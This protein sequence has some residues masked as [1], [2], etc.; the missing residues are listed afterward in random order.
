MKKLDLHVH[1]L[2]SN[3]D[4]QFEFDINRLKEYVTKRKIDGIAITNHN[5]FDRG[6][7]EE[8]ARELSQICVVLPGI[9][10]NLGD[11]SV[12]HMLCIA[13]PTDM[14]EFT[15]KCSQVSNRIRTAQDFISYEDLKKIFGDLSRYLWIPHYDKKPSIDKK[16]LVEMQNDILCGEVTSVKK[17][18]YCSKDENLLT[19]VYFSDFRSSAD[20]D[21]RESYPVRQ[22]YFDISEITLRTIKMCLSDKS[23]VVLNA[24]DGNAI[25]E[26]IPGLPISTGLNVMLGGRSSGKTFTLNEIA[27]QHENIK[28]IKQF[29]LIEP[30]P[31]KAAKEFTDN[32]ANKR[33][34][35]EELYFKEFTEVVDDIKD[36]SIV[37]DDNMVGEYVQ[38]LVEHANEVDRADMF[39]KCRLYE[40][41]EFP[42]DNPEGLKKL[43]SSVQT[44]LEEHEYR[45]VIDDFVDRTALIHLFDE[46]TRIYSQRREMD[47]KKQWINGIVIDIKNSLQLKTSST[48][49]KD[50]DLYKVAINRVKIKK[51]NKLVEELKKTS[52]IVST[53]VGGF[54]V[55][56][57]KKPF[58]SPSELRKRSGKRDVRFSDMMNTYN[59]N[60]YSFLISLKEVEAIPENEYYKYFADVEYD[61]LNQYNASI[62]GGERAEFT[63]L[64]QIKDA[65]QYDM[66]LIDEPESSFDNIFLKQRVNEIIKDIADKIPVII[67]THNNTVGESIKP[68]YLIHTY[69]MIEAQQP[70]Y[71]LFYGRPSDKLLFSSDGDSIKNIDVVLD[72]LEAGEQAYL[73]RRHDYEMLKN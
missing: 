17:F 43:I 47:L 54:T 51:F 73:D 60:P 38:S 22:T 9:E 21:G 7:Y 11:R 66:L 27:R 12:G 64:Q 49:I 58:S 68:D 44:L 1:T 65:N 23:K 39:S 61:I 69:R 42:S 36:V 3:S 20:V 59:N 2:S 55:Q 45:T 25:F 13:E 8:I 15:E 5:L 50:V 37:S 31:E 32:I 71:K 19:P 30:D 4:K 67:V 24:K 14:P 56:I 70:V 26:V 72:Y 28:Y 40:E 41:S 52:V 6:Q 16:I 57:K 53:N 10:I 46:L 63:L 34:N 29:A 18:V 35:V 62:S 33:K 48:P